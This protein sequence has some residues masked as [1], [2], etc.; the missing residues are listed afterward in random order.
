MQKQSLRERHLFF[1]ANVQKAVSFVSNISVEKVSNRTRQ[2]YKT[3]A[4]IIMRQYITIFLLIVIFSCK[5][6]E[7][8]D[9]EKAFY[10]NLMV[11]EWRIDSSSN[12]HFSYD[13]LILLDDGN[14]YLFS[15]SNGGSLLTNG[16]KFGNSKLPTISHD[17]LEISI[18]DSN[19]ICVSGGWSNVKDFYR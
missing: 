14:F 10:D 12:R 3:L 13:R 16:R 2:S 6:K 15:G 5:N 1:F 9:T 8:P 4:A 19:R 7:I 11:G 18:L 17:T